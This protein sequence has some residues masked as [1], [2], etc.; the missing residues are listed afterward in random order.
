MRTL[1]KGDKGEEVKLLQKALNRAGANLEV[2][3]SYGPKTTQAVTNFQEDHKLS[4]DGVCGPATQKALEPYM[5]DYSLVA[6]ALEEC[7]TAVEK[8]PEYK[9]LEALLYG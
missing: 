5:V 2:D 8:L 7:L 3:G 4:P 9:R 6:D 1:R